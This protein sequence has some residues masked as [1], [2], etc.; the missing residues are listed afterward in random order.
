MA[1]LMYTCARLSIN[2]SRESR[3]N[4][5]QMSG[6]FPDPGQAFNRLTL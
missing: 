5:E 2:K 6:L 3:E 4:I 1:N